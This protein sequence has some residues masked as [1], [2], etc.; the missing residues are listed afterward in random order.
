MGI[1]PDAAVICCGG[2]GLSAGCAIALHAHLPETALHTAEPTGWDDTARSLSAGERIANEG[3]V[4][5]LC[6]ALMA[7]I[8][9]EL[10]FPINRE[11]M[12]S[13]AAVDD[14]EIVAA[15]LAANRHFK[16][17]AEPGGAAALAVALSGKVPV[18]GRTVVVVISGGNVDPATYAKLI[19]GAS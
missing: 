1:R 4:P 5:S 10:T 14:G 19:A 2:G 9:G 18:A 3:V 7:P 8:P 17:V 12:H 13:G 6:D 16:L 15:M 11:L